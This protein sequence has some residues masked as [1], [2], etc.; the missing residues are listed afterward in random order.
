MGGGDE[1]FL[2][3]HAIFFG[4]AWWCC[5]IPCSIFIRFLIVNC[6]ELKTRCGGFVV[7]FYLLLSLCFLQFFLAVTEFKVLY[8]SLKCFQVSMR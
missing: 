6:D 1:G 8:D 5:Q 7:P 4:S 3:F 2:W